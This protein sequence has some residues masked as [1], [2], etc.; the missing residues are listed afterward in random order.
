VLRIPCP[1]CG[2]RD[3]SEF[4]YGGDANVRRPEAAADGSAWLDYVY[5]RDNPRGP[6]AELWQHH[7]GC[8]QWLRVVRDTLTHRILAVDAVGIWKP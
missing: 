1:W 5:V 3:H 4:H 7:A 6:H 8:R 2:E